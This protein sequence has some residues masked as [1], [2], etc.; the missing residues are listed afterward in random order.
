MVHKSIFEDKMEM[1]FLYMRD[2]ILKASEIGTR[3]TMVRLWGLNPQIARVLQFGHDNNIMTSRILEDYK[4]VYPEVESINSPNSFFENRNEILMSNKY[5]YY[6]DNNDMKNND[7]D[8]IDSSSSK[9]NCNNN[10][11]NNNRIS[12][13]NGNNNGN[14]Y[15][16]DVL[17]GKF[18]SN[19][20]ILPAQYPLLKSREYQKQGIFKRK[21]EFMYRVCRKL[22]TK[23]FSLGGRVWNS[24][25]RW[26]HI[27]GLSV[28]KFGISQLFIDPQ[29]AFEY[30][31]RHKRYS[32]FHGSKDQKMKIDKEIQNTIR[33]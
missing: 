21:E 31:Q 30:T 24:K 25:N 12:N 22:R 23:Y 2:I 3:G 20:K 16:G 4:E 10:F 7:F 6:I 26:R 19:P 9:S 28:V 11:N 32:E 27:G 18:F 29:K 33:K 17:S 14:N 8:D 1:A 5:K 13:N 15:N